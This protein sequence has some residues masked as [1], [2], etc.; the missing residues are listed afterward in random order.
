MWEKDWA[1]NLCIAQIALEN[2]A[3]LLHNDR[4]FTAIGSVC[5][6]KLYP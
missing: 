5:R 4:D 3:L 6:R 1:L 2:A